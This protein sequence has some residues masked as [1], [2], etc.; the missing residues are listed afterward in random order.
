MVHWANL[1]EVVNTDT[2]Q[3]NYING[4]LL[5]EADMLCPSI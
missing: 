2:D 4:E 5:T 1:A 3:A